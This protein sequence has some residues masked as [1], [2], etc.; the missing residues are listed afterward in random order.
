MVPIASTDAARA[1][2]NRFTV[3]AH[4]VTSFAPL[5]SA[6]RCASSPFRSR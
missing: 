2:R 6:A 4:L 5:M 1:A 3:S